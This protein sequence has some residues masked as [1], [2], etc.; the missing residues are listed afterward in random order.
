MILH[1]MFT[2]SLARGTKHK[3]IGSILVEYSYLDELVD[4]ML[5]SDPTERPQNI[6]AVKRQLRARQQE[7]FSA[8]RVS[9]FEQK[10]D[11]GNRFR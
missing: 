7:F 10:G 3:K 6:E 8:Q 5:S 9:D 11:S 1:E 4:Q 2:G